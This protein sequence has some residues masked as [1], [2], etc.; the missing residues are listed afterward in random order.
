MPRSRFKPRKAVLT[1]RGVKKV[2]RVS[3]RANSEATR[4]LYEQAAIRSKGQASAALKL[5]SSRLDDV[6]L[7]TAWEAAVRGDY[8]TAVV[9]LARTV[10]RTRTSTVKKPK[11][12]SPWR[13]ALLPRRK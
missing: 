1:S 12:W 5:A 3:L 2:R 11:G 9:R 10:N 8:E 4:S 13:N 7:D 6:E